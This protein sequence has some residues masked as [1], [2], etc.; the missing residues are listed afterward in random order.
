MMTAA[1][2]SICLPVLNGIDYLAPRMES[3]ICQSFEDWEL[4]VADSFSDDGSWEYL[5]TFKNDPRVRLYQIPKEGI[6]P[7]WNF[8]IEQARGDYLYIATA[9]DTADTQLIERLSELLDRFTDVSI[10]TCAFDYIDENGAILREAGSFGGRFYGADLDRAHRRPGL[11]EFLVHSFFGPSWTTITSVLFRRSIFEQVG[12]F[13]CDL[14]PYADNFWARL[15]ALESDTLYIPERLAT[16]RIHPQQRSRGRSS[17]HTTAKAM[18]GAAVLSTVEDRLPAEWKALPHWRKTLL[19]TD[20]NEYFGQFNL[21]RHKLRSH[22]SAFML[23]LLSAL[24]RNPAYVAQQLC[25]GFPAAPNSNLEDEVRIIEQF[26]QLVKP[27]LRVEEL[28]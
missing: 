7:A 25:K 17:Q 11:M 27:A 4:I 12:L 20:W 2:V 15:A 8:C 22:P 24:G 18:A 16:W 1:K 14:G 28:A 23:G 5:Q 9:D 3:L 19:Q 13:R 21:Y 10:A 26:C 6:Y